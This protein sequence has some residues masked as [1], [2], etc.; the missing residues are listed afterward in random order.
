MT[1]QT[2]RTHD[3]REL[4]AERIG[5]GAPTVVF[6]AGMGSSRVAWA[7]VTPLLGARVSA[8]VYDRSG[9][10][11]SAATNGPRD[12]AAL[13]RDLGEVL[14]QIGPGPF[15]LVGHSWGGPIVRVAAAAHPDRVA[16][17][18]LVDPSDERCDLFFRSSHSRF[19]KL[20]KPLAPIAARLGLF[21]RRVRKLAAHLPP[22][23]AAEMCAE[24]ASPAAITTSLA[25]METWTAD[26]RGLRD[27]PPSVPDVPITIISGGQAGRFERAKRAAL[28]DAHRGSAA[29]APQGRHVLATASNHFVPFTEPQVV[30]DEVLRIIDPPHP[31]APT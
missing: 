20:A 11:R 21:K 26:L 28:V 12:L 7:A 16:G 29:A 9:L 10:G 5:A 19:E 8:V 25:E 6:E 22:A 18:V 23:A 31:G 3:G 30:A 1:E 2:I 14:D 27:R 15:V 13:A 4:H 24:D 17:L